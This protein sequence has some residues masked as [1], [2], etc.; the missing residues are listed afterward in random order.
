METCISSS[1]CGY[2]VVTD[3]LAKY[4]QKYRVLV[5]T[6]LVL[7]NGGADKPGVFQI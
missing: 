7:E 6:L 2:D 4:H 3:K 1:W 5:R